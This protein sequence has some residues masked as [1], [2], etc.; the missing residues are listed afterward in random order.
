MAITRR[1][2]CSVTTIAAVSLGGCLGGSDDDG[3]SGDD[4]TANSGGARGDLEDWAWDGSL[5]VSTVVQHHDPSCGCCSIYVEYLE[6]HGI[7]VRVEETDDLEAVK[8]EHSVPEEA[9]SCHTVE[10]GDCLVEG[11]VPLEAIDELLAGEPDVR[12]IA[13]PGMP[14]FSPGMGPRG[15]EPLSIYAFDDSGLLEEFGAY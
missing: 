5:A 11:H 15:D 10:V 12:G 7:D 4:S 9:Q 13:A 8:A 1:A 6:T 2:F 3:A 14:R